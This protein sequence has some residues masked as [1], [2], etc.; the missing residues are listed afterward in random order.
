VLVENLD[1]NLDV[2]IK[3][4]YVDIE[5]ELFGVDIDMISVS[6]VRAVVDLSHLTPG[7]YQKKLIFV[8]PEKTGFMKSSPQEVEVTIR[9]K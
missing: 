7:V 5:L 4:Q 1:E 3:P 6:S 2:D 9:E 8:I